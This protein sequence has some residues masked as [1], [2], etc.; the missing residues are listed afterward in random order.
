MNKFSDLVEREGGGAN[1]Q[2]RLMCFA[3]RRIKFV[4]MLWKGAHPEHAN[5]N[6]PNDVGPGILR[7]LAFGD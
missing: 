3:L 2:L 7:H 5:L 4:D 1:S 6:G